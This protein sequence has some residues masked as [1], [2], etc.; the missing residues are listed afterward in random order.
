VSSETLGPRVVPQTETL[1]AWNVDAQK[2]QKVCIK[3]EPR[4]SDLSFNLMFSECVRRR[5]VRRVAETRVRCRACCASRRRRRGRH[6]SCCL[7]TWAAGRRCG[8]VPPALTL[9]STPSSRPP[10][11]CSLFLMSEICCNKL[12]SAKGFFI[13]LHHLPPQSKAPAESAYHLLRSFFTVLCV[14]LPTILNAN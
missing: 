8:S 4:E 9:P 12:S 2:R 5:A 7:R 14:F 10:R 6:S 11:V 1:C 13:P 3:K